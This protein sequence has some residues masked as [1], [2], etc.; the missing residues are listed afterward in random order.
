MINIIGTSA[1]A[2][3]QRTR[4]RRL[5]ET[6]DGRCFYCGF[7][8]QC[9]SEPMLRDWLVPGRNTRMVIEHKTPIHRGGS[10]KSDNNV[11]ACTLCNSGKGPMTID[12]YRFVRGLRVGDMSFVFFGERQ[13]FKR[14]WL[15][16]HSRSF[17]RAILV[18]NHPK[19]GVAYSRGKRGRL[20]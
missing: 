6:T 20:G 10:D 13:G 15:C 16:C 14:D 2:K 11:P 19:A 4:R 1:A 12:E 17:E 9:D 5:Y 3:G 8:L 18:R 7:P